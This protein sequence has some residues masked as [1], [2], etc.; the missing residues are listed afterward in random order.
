M[1][2]VTLNEITFNDAKVLSRMVNY[3]N[4]LTG[5]FDYFDADM[6]LN[7][8]CDASK[9]F[10]AFESKKYRIQFTSNAHKLKDTIESPYTVETCTF[11]QLR[12]YAIDCMS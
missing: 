8:F 7:V 2:N 4:G 11:N 6:E 10:T 5:K 1:T 3:M 12:K 9:D